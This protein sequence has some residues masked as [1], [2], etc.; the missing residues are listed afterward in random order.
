LHGL[1]P[2]QTAPEFADWERSVVPE[3]RERLRRY[4]E[5]LLTGG[6]REL[7]IE[8]RVATASG[9]RWLLAVGDVER[10]AS[11]RALRIAG[12][13]LDVTHE[14][15][16]ASALA[17]SEQALREAD[18]R[19]D[20]FL[21]TLAHEL[22][23]PL[24]PVRNA[25]R[26]LANPATLPAQQRW[27]CEVIERQVGT[28]ARLLDDLLDAARITSGKL[29]LRRESVL[30]WTVMG[31]AVETSR[32]LIEA[33]DH[34][35]SVVLPVEPVRIDADA[36]RI[37]QI[38]VNLLNNAAKY[39][40]PGGRIDLV[41]TT[42]A[43]EIRI[44]VRDTGVGLAP[45][46]L[47]RVFDMFSQVEDTRAHGDSGLGI[48]LAL[49]KGLVEL[50]GGRVA[51]H[52]DGLGRGASFVVVLPV[53][54]PGTSGAGGVAASEAL[55]GRVRTARRVLIADDNRDNA[56]SLAMLLGMDGHQVRIGYSGE[57][58]LQIA[59][60][61]EPEIALLDI[62]MPGLSGYDV[63]RRLRSMSMARRPTLVAVTGWGQETD[64]RAAA[65]A[66]FDRH[67]TKP[68]SPD[69]ISALLQELL[70]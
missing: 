2:S 63:A 25:V 3:D 44:E 68:V 60:E 24:A 50:H 51:A 41:A 20:E 5:A 19:K 13:N 47:P 32:P 57:Q 33:R 16:T 4:I 14:K 56:D 59:K 38:I 6:E 42:E 15:R 23:N 27:S 54:P 65:A 39:T 30:V 35:L 36:V 21:A 52:S 43:N 8:F 26:V 48:G 37:C 70:D 46:A 49:V 55:G 61:F 40:P 62:G 64:K 28:M 1:A 53:M 9:E 58:A 67:L 66:G 22:R 69:S 34:T 45:E 31:Q 10:D 29:E 12:L 7:R 11:G 18:R 17:S